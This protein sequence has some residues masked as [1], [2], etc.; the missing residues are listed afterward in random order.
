[1]YTCENHR[2][3]TGAENMSDAAEIIAGRKARS[4][5][6]R[7]GY[8]RTLRL[9]C[10]SQD[11]SVGEFESFIGYRTAQNETTGCNVRFTIT[12]R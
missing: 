3:I 5:F 2:P 8:A 10:W 1:M 9:D 6:G 11:G 4:I 7:R 12:K